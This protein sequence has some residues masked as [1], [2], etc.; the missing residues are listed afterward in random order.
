MTHAMGILHIRWPMFGGVSLKK[1][2][3]LV[4]LERNPI[5]IITY[6][7]LRVQLRRR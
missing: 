5:I 6:S 7:I 3:H 2:F 4:P 1:I